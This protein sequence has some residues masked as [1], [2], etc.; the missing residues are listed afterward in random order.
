MALVISSNSD[1]LIN[2][3]KTRIIQIE[4]KE[5][6]DKDKFTLH[7]L[8]VEYQI[9]DRD[10]WKSMSDRWAELNQKALQAG[11]NNDVVMSDD[12]IAEM[13]E[14]LYET[15]A[16]YINNIGPLVDE[17]KQPVEFTETIKDALLQQPWLQQPL[18]DG[19]FAAQRG[20]TMADFKRLRA[21]N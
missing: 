6:G 21:K 20:L 3:K 15:A 8:D 19:F 14:P 4:A 10:L 9:I 17:N 18:A 2:A 13:R 16:P 12:E 7:K 11:R 1:D 5:P